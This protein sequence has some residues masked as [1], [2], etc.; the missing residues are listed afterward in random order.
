MLSGS[1]RLERLVCNCT[2]EITVIGISAARANPFVSEDGR[3]R[4]RLLALRLL[5]FLELCVEELSVR[6]DLGLI[7]LRIDEPLRIVGIARLVFVVQI[8]LARVRSHPDVGLQ[9]LPPA[10]SGMPW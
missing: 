4:Q 2:C 6:S 5:L 9:L 10:S 7:T 3:A 1:A 8:E